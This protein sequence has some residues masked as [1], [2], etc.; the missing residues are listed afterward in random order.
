MDEN[1]KH[2]GTARVASNLPNLSTANAWE[3]EPAAETF[4]VIAGSLR[5]ARVSREGSEFLLTA[6]KIDLTLDGGTYRPTR[7]TLRVGEVEFEFN[8]SAPT[9][10][11]EMPT[12]ELLAPVQSATTASGPAHP[13]SVALPPVSQPFDA[14]ELNQIEVS[15]R[16]GLH[17]LRADLGE[18]IR[19]ERR[20][21]EVEIAGVVDSS[22]RKEQIL[23]AFRNAAHVRVSLLSPEDA[24]QDGLARALQATPA[25]VERR[26][27]LLES[28][29]DIQFP[30]RTQQEKWVNSILVEADICLQRAHAIGE[31]DSRYG[32]DL[33]PAIMSLRD[34]HREALRNTWIQLVTMLGPLV[35]S[36]AP[37]PV[38]ALVTAGTVLEDIRAL[39]RDLSAL[40]AGNQSDPNV[41]QGSDKLVEDARTRV[42][43]IGTK[44]TALTERQ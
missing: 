7:E 13:F 21:Q 10:I 14:E 39:Q 20:E 36:E 44:I 27:P 9:T 33:P 35:G 8:E 29:L 40:L 37:S 11:S 42:R 23:E 17:Q 43:E 32:T 31:V 1:G 2:V 15:V 16:I 38:A 12:P 5:N 41:I 34:D 26:P 3:F 25:I 4:A 30:D 19:I 18:A 22:A 24:G 6:Q 28:W